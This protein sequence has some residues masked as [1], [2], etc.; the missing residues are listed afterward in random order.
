MAGHI[1]S[2]VTRQKKSK[3]KGN[4]SE[5]KPHCQNVRSPSPQNL[6]RDI[7]RCN[8]DLNY[9]ILVHWSDVDLAQIVPVSPRFCRLEILINSVYK[10]KL[11]SYFN[12]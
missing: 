6:P 9:S 7:L 10:K 8:R 12:V 3:Q 2:S 4:L 1:C 5:K 11:M